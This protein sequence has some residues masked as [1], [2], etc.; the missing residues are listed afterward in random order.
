MLNTL[1]MFDSHFHLID[2]QFPVVA[3]N[4]YLP[5]PFTYSDY[6]HKTAAYNI[7]GGAIVSGSFQGF[8]QSYLLG[9]LAKLGPTFV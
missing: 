1:P 8:D 4:G 2:P 6:L 9:A 7:C 3:N 5:E